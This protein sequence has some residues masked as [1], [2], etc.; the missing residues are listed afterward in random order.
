MYT[1]SFSGVGTPQAALMKALVPK[2][3]YSYRKILFTPYF[4]VR[5]IYHSSMTEGQKQR[6]KQREY[7]I[8]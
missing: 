7:L 8:F 5:F 2:P 3:S 4:K 1:T 6:E